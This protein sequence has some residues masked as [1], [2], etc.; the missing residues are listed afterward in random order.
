MNILFVCTGNINRSPASEIIY[1]SLNYR[2]NVTSAALTNKKSLITSKRM[3]E[4]L[5]KAGYKYTEI[6]SKPVTKALIDWADTILYMQKSHLDQLVDRFGS[7]H[8]YKNLAS[9]IG[10][11]KIHDPAFDGT[12]ESVIKDIEMA[13]KIYI[14]NKGMNP[15]LRMNRSLFV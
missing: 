6:R 10:K 11:N 1:K 8:K 12:Q 3:R 7:S 2:D 9:Y 5:E 15:L 13:I 14:S 4:A